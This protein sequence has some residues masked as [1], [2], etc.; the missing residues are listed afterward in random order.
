MKISNFNAPLK[1]GAAVTDP[2]SAHDP[3]PAT[4]ASMTS[5][6]D[7]RDATEVALL[8]ARIEHLELVVE[9]A[10]GLMTANQERLLR[11][12]H[13]VPQEMMTLTATMARLAAT[14]PAPAAEA[15]TG[16]IGAAVTRR[17]L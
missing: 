6:T 16:A 12:L 2:L 5:A 8:R 7:T 14:G 15:E 13:D 17:I 3:T 4:D 1:P 9:T 10:R 11:R